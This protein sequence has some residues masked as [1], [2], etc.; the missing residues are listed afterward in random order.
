MREHNII[1]YDFG[2]SYKWSDSHHTERTEGNSSTNDNYS[3]YQSEH[4]SYFTSFYGCK[5]VDIEHQYIESGKE[6]QT[7]KQHRKN[8]KNIFD[9]FRRKPY[10]A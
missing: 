5:S 9:I 2:F 4:V 10:T 6:Y 3:T 1:G 8:N 7:K